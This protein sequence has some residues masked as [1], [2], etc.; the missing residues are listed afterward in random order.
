MT[1]TGNEPGQ[2]LRPALTPSEHVDGAA[3]GEIFER[4]G[5]VVRPDRRLSQLVHRRPPG[6]TGHQWNTALRTHF[7]FVACNP[8]SY[9][10]EVAVEFVDPKTRASD[11]ERGERMTRAVCE[12][13][14]LKLLRVE[15]PTLRADSYGRRL[16]EYV[17]DGHRFLQASSGADADDS[18]G[19]RDIVGR[20]PDGRIGP[21]N[22][23]GIAARAAAVEAYVSRQLVDPLIRGLHVCWREG[24][25]EGWAWAEVRSGRYLFERVR[26]WLLAFDFG[27]PPGQFAEDLAVAGI[28]VRLQTLDLAEPVLHDREHLRRRLEQLKLRRDDLTTDFAYDHVS[29]G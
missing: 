11:A 9:L 17:I 16:V 2:W 19:Y 7:D 5:W 3:R 25:A 1:G 26:I 4:G 27:V 15:S 18:P 29:F 23:L 24:P 22:D 21:V 6:I 12:A 20:L 28:G 8:H 14:G 13:I 10:P